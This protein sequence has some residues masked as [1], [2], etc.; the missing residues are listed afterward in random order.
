MAAILQAIFSKCT[1]SDEN[2]GISIEI[3]LKFV[4]MCLNNNILALV[5]KRG[6]RRSGDEPL[7]ALI[8]AQI[9]DTDMRHSASMNELYSIP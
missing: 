5:P 1:F 4:P 9:T 8:M 7:S 6:W 2:L 3:S